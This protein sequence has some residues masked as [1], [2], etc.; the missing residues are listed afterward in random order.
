MS[1]ILWSVSYYVDAE[2]YRQFAG[3]GSRAWAQER[4]AY[5]KA[6]GHSQVK[7]KWRGTG[8]AIAAVE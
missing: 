8:E 3:E 2:R 4:A 1:N 6:T 5:L 7:I